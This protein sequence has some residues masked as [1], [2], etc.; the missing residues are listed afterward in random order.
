MIDK[1][2]IQNIQEE[3]FTECNA[4]VDMLRIDLLHPIVSGNKLF[5]LKYYIQEAREKNKNGIITLGGSYSNHLVASAYAAKKI[6]LSSIGL[7]RGE[8]PKELSNTLSDCIIHGME[9]QFI[10]REAFDKIDLHD[11]AAKYPTK[12]IIPQGG[13]GF[14]GAKGASEILSFEGSENY[15][16]IIAACGTGTMAAGLINSS[17]SSQKIILVSVLKNNFSIINEIR[18][19]ITSDKLDKNK[20]DML[21]NYHHGG[22]AKKDT[23]LLETMN[24]FYETHQIKTDFVYT[25]KMISAFYD[26]MKNNFFLPGSRIL[27]IHSGGLQGNRSLTNNELSF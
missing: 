6:G 16:H 4:T 10:T 3:L 18:K 19:L 26:S 24:S 11:L 1:S 5:K 27:L 2:H 25:G 14:L 22:Y 9:L 15:S 12:Q 23:A 20:F 8:R 17:N 13:Y 21:F 7:V